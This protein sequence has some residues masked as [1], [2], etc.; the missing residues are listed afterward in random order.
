[1]KNIKPTRQSTNGTSF[2]EQTLVASFDKMIQVF[3]IPQFYYDDK[4]TCEWAFEL[5]DGTVFTIY[6]WKE[7]IPPAVRSH[8]VFTWHIGSHQILSPEQYTTIKN[9]LI[10][11]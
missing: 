11:S 9:E 7:Y 4:V 3:G 5:N 6:D 2:F 1:M 8:L 10:Q